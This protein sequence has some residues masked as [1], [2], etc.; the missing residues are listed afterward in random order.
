[1]IISLLVQFNLSLYNSISLHSADEPIQPTR[2]VLLL[3]Q[4]SATV[5]ILV[6]SFTPWPS[7]QR[8]SHRRVELLWL[9]GAGADTNLALSRKRSLDVAAQLQTTVSAALWLPRDLFSL[10]PS[11]FDLAHYG[12]T[13]QDKARWSLARFV[14]VIPK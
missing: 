8:F 1:M 4:S 6:G 9:N 5:Y 12:H 10:A 14:G 11:A 13:V 3:G 2:E 7:S